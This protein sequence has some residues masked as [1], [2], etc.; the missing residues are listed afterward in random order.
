MKILLLIII[1]ITLVIV[2][3]R[4]IIITRV[5]TLVKSDNMRLN[6]VEKMRKVPCRVPF[7]GT[8]SRWEQILLLNKYKLLLIGIAT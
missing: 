5:H 4:V 3:T 8:S 7:L 1:I 2:I 6:H